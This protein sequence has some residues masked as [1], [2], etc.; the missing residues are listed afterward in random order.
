[1]QF[2]RLSP[3]TIAKVDSTDQEHNGERDPKVALPGSE[4]RSEVQFE[5]GRK[6]RWKMP[7]GDDR[8]LRGQHG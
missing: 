5:A 2:N 8:V 1:M 6:R 7:P 4:I 3:G